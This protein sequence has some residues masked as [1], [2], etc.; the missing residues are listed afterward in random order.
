MIFGASG[1]KSR[2]RLL[3]VLLPDNFVCYAPH[4]FVVEQL[5]TEAYVIQ[6]QHAHFLDKNGEWSNGR[7]NQSVYRTLHKDEAINV[8]VEQSVRNPELRLR[9]IPCALNDKGQ[10]QITVQAP[11]DTAP[12]VDPAPTDSFSAG[13]E[14]ANQQAPLALDEAVN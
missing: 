7:E 8:K 6:N 14:T 5:M 12:A 13:E 4:F 2:Y 1:A 9:V 10:P 11:D 3:L